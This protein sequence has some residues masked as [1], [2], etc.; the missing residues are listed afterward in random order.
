MQIELNEGEV[1]N[2]RKNE[3]RGNFPRHHAYW[4]PRAPSGI[5]IQDVGGM[6]AQEPKL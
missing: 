5:E 2:N 6:L 4:N 3:E 1:E